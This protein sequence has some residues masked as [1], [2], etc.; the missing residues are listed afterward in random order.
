[1]QAETKETLLLLGKSL[2]LIVGGL[3]AVA[4]LVE[5]RVGGS[6]PRAWGTLALGL[7]LA[8]PPLGLAFRDA[9]RSR[10]R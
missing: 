9:A 10:R 4:A 6:S 7:L 2:L 3:F 5:L 1:M 8:L